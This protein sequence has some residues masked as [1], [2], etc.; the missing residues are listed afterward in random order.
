MHQFI[1]FLI[2]LLAAHSAVLA[3]TVQDEPLQVLGDRYEDVVDSDRATARTTQ[4]ELEER[5]PQSTPAALIF[6]PGV[7]VQ[8]TAHGQG[9]PYIRGRTGQQ[10]LLLF[11]GLRLNH[12]LFRKGPNQYLFTVDS[13]TLSGI[14]VIRGSASVELGNDAIS[15]AVYLRP[16]EPSIDPTK[17]QLIIQPTVFTRAG[18]ADGELGGR[19]QLDTQFN[20]Y[21]GILVGLGGRTVGQLEAGGDA[22]PKGQLP[23][24]ACEDIT[25]VPCFESDG[26]TQ[27]GTGFDELTGDVRAVYEQGRH[28]FTLA[29]YSTGSSM[30]LERTNVHLEAAIGECLNYDEQFRTHVYAKWAYEPKTRFMN[31]M[32]TSV[33]FQ[34]QHQRYT[35]RRPAVRQEMVSIRQPLM[36]VETQS[37]ATVRPNE[38]QLPHGHRVHSS[39]TSDTELTPASKPSTASSGFNS[40]NQRSLEFS[41]EVN[42]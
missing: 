14:D 15:G 20:K 21:F 5:Q 12:A 24:Q 35:L 39:W 29:T 40:P 32:E 7:Y 11:D 16:L 9:S 36:G 28:R 18:T 23:G 10:T 42:M 4:K 8:Q 33:S 30:P 1:L 19:I 31:T 41:V 13:R 22:F 6:S 25:S 38:L 27:K 26:R 17:D 2:C 37:M 34:R 3:D